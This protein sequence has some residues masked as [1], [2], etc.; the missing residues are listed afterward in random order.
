MAPKEILRSVQN[1]EK[2]EKLS[3]QL[4]VTGIRLMIDPEKDDASAESVI[5][6]LCRLMEYKL[7]VNAQIA[8]GNWIP[9]EGARYNCYQKY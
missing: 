9:P 7:V 5:E 6:D 8:A 3:S 2:F 1:L 4:G